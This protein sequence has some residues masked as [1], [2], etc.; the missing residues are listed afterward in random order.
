MQWHCGVN[1]ASIKANYESK[2]KN[3]GNVVSESIT[4]GRRLAAKFRNPPRYRC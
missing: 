4:L 1:E 3:V 2:T